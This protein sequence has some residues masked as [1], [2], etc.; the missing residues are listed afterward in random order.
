[1]KASAVILAFCSGLILMTVAPLPLRGESNEEY[2]RRL[3][4]ELASFRDQA[5]ALKRI[6][7][8]PPEVQT[9]GS[10]GEVRSRSSWDEAVRRQT[11]AAAQ[12]PPTPVPSPI[13]TLVTQADA[14]SGRGDFA[15]A[16]R[17]LS[18]ATAMSPNPALLA[19][20]DGL[21]AAKLNREVHDANTRR[22]T[23]LN[24]VLDRAQRNLP[25]Q[26]L[27]PAPTVA[28]A[29]VAGDPLDDT[30]TVDLRGAQSFVVDPSF[31]KPG[32]MRDA[33]NDGS[34]GR[35]T[36]PPVPGKPLPPRA[37]ADSPYVAVFETPEFT[38]LMLSGMEE[39][40]TARPGD[41]NRQR[42]AFL[43]RIDALPPQLIHLVT[44]A[45]EKELEASR[46][47]VKEAYESY[48][49]RRSE[50]LGA[51]ANATLQEMKSM[52]TGMENEGWFKK[53]DNLMEKEANDPLFNAT[54]NERARVVR[55]YAELYLDEAENRA[56]REMAARV[57]RIMKEN[58]K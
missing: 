57:T 13:D 19:K 24:G 46:L 11:P 25:A 21:R 53:G 32:P 38:A 51:A 15:E 23:E 17:L 37:F 6:P 5:A 10:N 44:T 39:G 1:M 33:P 20:L 12:P 41:L 14:A 29:N 49:K 8:R 27:L 43:R 30:M 7:Q 3:D 45:E 36:E 35:F 56:Y 48:R 9:L 26:L 58:S 2:G 40:P 16:I 42:Q 52:I 55:W 54:L 31:F 47:Q 18:Q 34:A 28:L 50:L 22:G 4:R